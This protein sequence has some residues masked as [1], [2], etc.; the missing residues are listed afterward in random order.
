MPSAKTMLDSYRHQVRA[1]RGAG[2]AGLAEQARLMDAISALIDVVDA[3]HDPRR[4][5][6]AV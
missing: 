1:S 2:L 5:S 4:D 3:D 6:V